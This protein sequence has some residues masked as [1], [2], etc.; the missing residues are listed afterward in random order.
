MMMMMNLP[1]HLLLS[2]L[3]FVKVTLHVYSTGLS[4]L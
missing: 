4:V 3:L 1:L 2:L